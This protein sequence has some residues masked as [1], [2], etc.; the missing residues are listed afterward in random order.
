MKIISHLNLMPKTYYRKR[1]SK[2]C[3]LIKTNTF[4]NYTLLIKENNFFSFTP[5]FAF[6]LRILITGLHR[7]YILTR[8]NN[9]YTKDE[10]H[11]SRGEKIVFYSFLFCG[12]RSVKKKEW[13]FTPWEC[14]KEFFYSVLLFLFK[15]F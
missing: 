2:I 6:E 1:R 11:W 3:F 10:R 8:I 15:A 12:L 5:I 7:F 4:L 14:K 13:I 9:N